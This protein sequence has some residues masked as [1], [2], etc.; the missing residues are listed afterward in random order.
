MSKA[1]VPI[2]GTTGKAL[3]F[4]PTAG[5]RALAAVEALRALL[6]RQTGTQYHR[7]LLELQVGD[8]HPQYTM[9]QARE[10]ITG[11]WDFVKP[12]WASDGSAALPGITWTA[13]TDSG[14]LRIGS[15][16][17]GMT[18]DGALRW[19][20]DTARVNQS[21]Y[22]NILNADADGG[23]RLLHPSYEGG[24]R[25]SVIAG[26]DP[27]GDGIGAELGFWE[28]DA[29]DGYR[30]YGIRLRHT[31]ELNFAGNLDFYRHNNDVNG[32]LFLR[33]TR[34]SSQVQFAS[35]SQT[36]PVVTF[37]DDI[38]SGIYLLATGHL[39]MSATDVTHVG[40]SSSG[41]RL[42]QR[43]LG[44]G[45]AGF[46]VQNTAGTDV[47]RFGYS[48]STAR[49]FFNVSVAA[50][51]TFQQAG[52]VM[53]EFKGAGGHWLGR[54][55]VELQLG[56]DVDM[57]LFHSGTAG[58]IRNN[59]GNLSINS[60]TTEVLRFIQ[61]ANSR[62]HALNG[63]A[64]LPTFGWFGDT[65][66]GFY[67]IGTD[68]FGTSAG[69]TLRQDWTTS[70]MRLVAD[71]YEL[72]IGAGQ[73]LRL[74]HDGTNSIIR[75][76]TGELRFEGSDWYRNGPAGTVRE[77][78]FESSGVQ[79]WLFRCTNTAEGG[80]NTGSDFQWISRTDAG[81]LNMVVLSI[82]RD[83]GNLLME[84]DNQELQIGASTDLRFYHNGTDSFI[85]NDTG[86]LNINEGATT[87]GRFDTN[88]TAGNTRFMVYDV[89][90]GTLERVSVGAADSGGTGYK[91]LRIPN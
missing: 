11:Q 23:F 58:T 65:N 40:T 59:T 48:N 78:G 52:T 43:N 55:G 39:G 75:N 21:V 42:I 33:M 62:V 82:R 66:N 53:W 19:D 34:D 81:G 47:L 64:A 9:W 80:G 84:N 12:I 32:V 5:E 24:V 2:W 35:G 6:A 70:A 26:P 60:G 13:D 90:N 67:Y 69:G 27:A 30:L 51:M 63:T 37:I 91:V 54:D 16:N 4:D 3:I 10:T 88:A 22:Q 57:R 83:N 89:D 77:F 1:K 28:N 61:G 29:T 76:D 68:N 41:T 7:D 49:P 73:D 72:Q 50:D 44:T 14:L 8:D 31:G 36:E 79:R 15:N 56:T 25:L 38:A 74:Y 87:V 45:T 85:R 20:I 46:T 17:F 71:N 86:V 18:T